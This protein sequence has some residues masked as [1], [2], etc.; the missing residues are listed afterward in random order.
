VRDNQAI[1]FILPGADQDGLLDASTTHDPADS[2]NHD[3]VG[4][5][6]ALGTEIYPADNSQLLDFIATITNRPEPPL[7]PSPPETHTL[8]TQKQSITR[9]SSVRPAA[10]KCFKTGNNRD[11]ISKAQEIILAK[12]NNSAAKKSIAL[13]LLTVLTLMIHLSRWRVFS[14]NLSPRSKWRQSW[15]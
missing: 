1:D 11:A 10:K 15:S 3:F 7:I 13:V 8:K 5:S 6:P 4:A 2:D 12:L 9:R 14:Q